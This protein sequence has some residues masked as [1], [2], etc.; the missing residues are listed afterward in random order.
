MCR[1]VGVHTR[2]NHIPTMSNV[3]AQLPYNMHLKFEK[4]GYIQLIQ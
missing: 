2:V 3:Y 1:L 4:G